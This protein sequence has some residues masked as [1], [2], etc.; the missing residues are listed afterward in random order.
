M[1]LNLLERP[2]STDEDS[3]D[4]GS[5]QH[6]QSDSPESFLARCKSIVDEM[7]VPVQS[8]PLALRHRVQAFRPRARAAFIKRRLRLLTPHWNV[9]SARR[10]EKI[11]GVIL[12][13]IAALIFRP[14]DVVTTPAL[15]DSESSFI[16]EEPEDNTET[17]DVPFLDA[18]SV[19]PALLQELAPQSNPH[20]FS[21]F[22][23]Y[24]D[25]QKRFAFETEPHWKT[26]YMMSTQAACGIAQHFQHSMPVMLRRGRSPVWSARRHQATSAKRIANHPLLV[27]MMRQVR[28]EAFEN[29]LDRGK[30]NLGTVP[31]SH[32]VHQFHS[33]T[34]VI[35]ESCG[36]GP[37]PPEE[38]AEE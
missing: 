15:I 1:A 37:T 25:P 10:L 12:I 32:V 22:H 19:D 14:E 31:M 30:M 16:S 20:P 2:A 26:N 21:R 9:D 36:P 28:K 24:A 3:S 35:N 4:D 11:L 38:E 18:E 6:N 5:A 29:Y 8:V 23:S 27:R 17:V 33:L 34:H 7:T 13:I